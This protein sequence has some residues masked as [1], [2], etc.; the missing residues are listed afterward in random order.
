MLAS[1]VSARYPQD[2][3]RRLAR[4][5]AGL[6][7][8]SVVASAQRPATAA[9]EA[10]ST[11]EFARLVDSLS[12]PG[13]YFDTDNL[14]SNEASYLHVTG[15]L[16]RMGVRGGAYIGVGPDQSFSYIAS[17]RSEIAF[18]VDIRR[19]NLL[20]H[21]LFKALFAASRSR[22]DYL[23]LLLGVP[24]TTDARALADRTVSDLVSMIDTMSAT[25]AS[26]VQ[27]RDAVRARVIT[28]GV[29]LSP[30]DLATIDRFHGAFMSAGLDLRF[31]S[32]G[33]APRPY[34][35]TLRDLILER[36]REG[37]QASYLAS[38]ADFQ[39]V[40]EL[41]RR[42]LIIPVVGDLGGTRAVQRIGS[43]LRDRELSLSVLYA[44]NAEDYVLRDGKFAQ[45][46]ANVNALPRSARSVIVRSWFGGPGTHLHSVPG[47]FSAQLLQT[48]DAFSAATL[49]G[50]MYSY[51]QLVFTA[52]VQP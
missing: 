3:R 15:A 42:N 27:A 22:A 40:K 44:S 13:G 2:M 28:F 48:I 38:E 35:P 21:L 26:R 33:R 8:F 30:D 7:L 46:V 52:H 12:E 25:L 11:A 51:R 10:L 4:A 6:L 32:A 17:T 39:Y 37:S 50:G 34:Y 45:Y 18:I 19:D 29:T 49:Q 43:V 16:A 47:Y 5:F 9:R 14:I 1:T 20:Q 31:A 41:Q 36:D 24:L 23:A